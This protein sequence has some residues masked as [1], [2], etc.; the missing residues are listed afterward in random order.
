MLF[1]ADEIPVRVAQVK[2][3]DALGRRIDVT[4]DLGL[5]FLD[6]VKGRPDVP[7]LDAPSP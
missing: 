4:E 6:M 3:P 7:R 1:D 5:V 2:G